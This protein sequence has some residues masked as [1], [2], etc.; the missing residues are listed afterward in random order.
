VRS[1]LFV[2]VVVAIVC[3]FVVA[4]G[5]L[6]YDSSQS[7]T[8]AKGIK[9]GGVDVGGLSVG[10]AR[11]R[12]R[13]HYDARLRRAIVARFRDRQFTLSP[14]AAAVSIDIDASVHEALVHTRQSNLLV[15][16]LRSLT[17]GSI[18]ADLE[19]H[20]T[21]SRAAVRNFT[22]RVAGSL[23]RPARDATLAFS[24]SGIH[25]IPSRI[26]LA[27]RTSQLN[28]RLE[29]SLARGI[30]HRRIAVPVVHTKP[31]V[32]T[33]DQLAT[34]YPTVITIDRSAFTLR[35]FKHLKLAKTYTIAVGQAGLETPAG[36]HFVIDKEVDPPWHVPN[37][38]WAG[39]LA[40]QTI[41]PGPQD[42]LKAR[43]IGFYDGDGIHGTDDTSSLGSAASHG[44]IRMSVS[45][46]VEL[47]PQVP[48]GAPV[49]VA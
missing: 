16:V 11:T 20:L 45:D 22:Q 44:C 48:M 49:F 29:D 37:S 2:V 1:R 38:S 47:Y 39:S 5:V 24:G 7:Q 8:I 40:G 12:L 10:Q 36:L 23:D 17:G 19:P 31:K 43:W 33:Q 35:L 41:P 9:V 32:I 14:R 26:G 13:A 27:V 30:A 42:P 3:L 4:G 6:A 28:A 46:V 15:R 21:Y 34:R 25:P 18:K